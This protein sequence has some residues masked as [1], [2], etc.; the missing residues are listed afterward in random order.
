V[1][2]TL[3]NI[4]YQTDN[5]AY[6]CFCRPDQAPWNATG[7]SNCNLILLDELDYLESIGVPMGYLSFQGAGVSSF[8]RA[9]K[10]A[11]PWCVSTWGVDAGGQEDM[12]PLSI[13]DFQKELAQHRGLMPGEF[14]LQ[15]Y[16]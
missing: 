16:T 9:D 8:N 1:D 3:T 2:I 4:G 15:L 14:P 11:A 7:R 13:A 5:G 10:T 6:Y 12:Y